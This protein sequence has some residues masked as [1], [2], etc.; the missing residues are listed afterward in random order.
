MRWLIAAGLAGCSAGGQGI[1][2]GNPPSMQARIAP[3][4]LADVSPGLLD[5][6]V[7][8]LEA[9]DPAGERGELDTD[10]A[11]RLDEEFPIE[12]PVGSWCALQVAGQVPLTLAVETPEGNAYLEVPINRV[13]IETDAPVEVPEGD[14]ELV[15]ELGTE[16]FLSAEALGLAG[17]DLEIFADAC[18]SNEIC[19]SVRDELEEGSA[20]YRDRDEDGEVD[21]SER[22][23]G[24]VMEGGRRGEG[25]TRR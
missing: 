8:F 12:I 20:A 19:A 14:F 16:G 10:E 22:D 1:L 21:D 17:R 15:L 25:R 5:L 7:G 24:A 11:W 9:C 23:D 18:L 6:D 2:V 4:R 13:R 3:S